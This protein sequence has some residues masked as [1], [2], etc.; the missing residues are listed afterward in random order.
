MAVELGLGFFATISFMTVK[1]KE[2]IWRPCHT[3]KKISSKTPE[4]ADKSLEMKFLFNLRPVNALDFYNFLK[5]I[6]S[7]FPRWH[8]LKIENITQ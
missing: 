5:L 2:K 6:C 4:E 3:V 7:E 1:E 8:F